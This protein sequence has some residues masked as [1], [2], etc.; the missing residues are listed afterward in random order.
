MQ[1]VFIKRTLSN[2]RSKYFPNLKLMHPILFYNVYLKLQIN[3]LIT[4]ALFLSSWN[5]YCLS[6]YL[7]KNSDDLL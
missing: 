1:D 7:V 3:F 6:V 4:Y 2:L 5:V